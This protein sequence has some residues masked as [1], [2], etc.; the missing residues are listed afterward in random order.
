M[1]K[2]EELLYKA[3]AEGLKDEVF[4]ESKKLRENSSKWKFR[5]YSDCIEEA[6]KIVKARKDKK[7]ENL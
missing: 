3:L 1:S 2:T 4:A 5:E 7:D 6:Y